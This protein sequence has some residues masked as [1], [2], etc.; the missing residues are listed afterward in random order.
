MRV[1]SW[2][3]S[4]YGVPIVAVLVQAAVVC[5]VWVLVRTSDDP[6]AGMAWTL[7]GWLDWPFSLAFPVGDERTIVLAALTIGSLHW[8]AIGLEVQV[9]VNGIRICRANRNAA[10]GLPGDDNAT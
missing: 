6:E 5:L 9:F 7:V 8:L 1:L 4:W 2:L 10:V 3:L